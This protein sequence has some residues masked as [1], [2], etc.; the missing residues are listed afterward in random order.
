MLRITIHDT[1]SELRLRLEGRLA[2]PWVREVELCCQTAQSTLRDR[3]LVVDLREVDFVDA[4]GERWLAAMYQ[5]GAKFLASSAL[6]RHLVRQI[7]GGPAEEVQPTAPPRR[8]ARLRLR[9]LSL[10]L[11]IAGGGLAADLPAPK[12]AI[13]RYLSATRLAACN[14]PAALLDVVVDAKLPKLHKQG[15]LRALQFVPGFGPASYRPVRF[16]GDP[17]IERSV[18]ARYLSVEEE[19]RSRGGGSLAVT[20]A[21]YRFRFERMSDYNGAQAYVFRLEPRRK[22]TGLFRGELWL[23]SR[24]FLPLREWGELVKSPSLF[25]KRVYFVRDY[26][27]TEG[28]PVPRRL[29]ANIDTRL[30]GTA[31]LTVW[32]DLR[33]ATV[34]RTPSSGHTLL[35]QD[36]VNLGSQIVESSACAL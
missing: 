35:N 5:R 19:A 15:R 23:D 27:I 6:T 18:I 22:R 13:A 28:R 2:G 10:F 3:S 29:I 8:K 20:P 9:L 32:S 24:T 26:V 1:P 4:A 33:C 12:E 16:E 17:T 7:T 14:R 21:N 11:T 25:V 36:N 31:E 30:A 34:E